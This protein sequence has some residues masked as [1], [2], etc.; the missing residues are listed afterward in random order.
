LDQRESLGAFGARV[1]ALSVNRAL[2]CICCVLSSLALGCGKDKILRDELQPPPGPRYFT[3]SAPESTVLNYKLA[4]ERRDS[5]MID[6]VLTDDYVGSSVDMTDPSSGTLT[7]TRSD[8]TRALGGIK[9]D[10]LINSVTIT[11]PDPSSWARHHDLGDPPEWVTFVVSYVS[12]LVTRTDTMDYAT[13]THVEF[14]V[15]P[16][17]SASDTTWKIIRW[18]EVHQ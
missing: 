5:T 1:Y 7:F 4:W 16:I 11:L 17:A 3:P 12:I 13:H 14:K 10:A 9:L 18:S 15:K 6:S 2:L 8:E